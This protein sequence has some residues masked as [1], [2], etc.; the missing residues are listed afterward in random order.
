M[1]TKKEYKKPVT[2]VVILDEVKTLCAGS[3]PTSTDLTEVPEY[4]DV[5]P[6]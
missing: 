5:T 3:D 2:K 1:K 4:E 6:D